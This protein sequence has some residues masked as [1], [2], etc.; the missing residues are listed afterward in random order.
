MTETETLVL[1]HLRA[2]RAD[3]SEIKSSVREAKTRLGSLEDLNV[4]LSGLYR[5]LFGLYVSVSERLDSLV[6][7]S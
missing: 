3:L 1:E 6:A 2:I 7:R 4:G 5:S